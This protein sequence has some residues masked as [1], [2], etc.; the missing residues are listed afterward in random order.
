MGRHRRSVAIHRDGGLVTLKIVPE[1]R[2]SA[3][4]F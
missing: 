4:R 2:F 1:E 3:G